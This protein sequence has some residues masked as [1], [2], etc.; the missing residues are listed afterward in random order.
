MEKIT[1]GI[2]GAS[3]FLASYIASVTIDFSKLAEIVVQ[4]IILLV[5]LFKMFEK[6][7]NEE[8]K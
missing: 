4:I 7:K 8:K 2:I 5:T 3:G 1:S 6:K